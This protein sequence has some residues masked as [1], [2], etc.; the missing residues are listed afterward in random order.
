MN[1]NNQFKKIP[2]KLCQILIPR[3]ELNRGKGSKE[4]QEKKKDS[5]GKVGKEKRGRN[6]AF[7]GKFSLF[8]IL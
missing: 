4:R 7:E 5:H 6:D 1:N 3:I 2:T 8:K